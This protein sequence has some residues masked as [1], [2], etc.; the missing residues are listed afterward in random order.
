[1]AAA[2]N[3]QF[4]AKQSRPAVANP[5]QSKR[6]REPGLTL[7]WLAPIGLVEMGARV[8]GAPVGM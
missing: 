3:K 4:Q 1:M 6:Q 2:I 5:H 7:V 8:I